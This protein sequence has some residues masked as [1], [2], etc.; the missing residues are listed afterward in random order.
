MGRELV[1]GKLKKEKDNLYIIDDEGNDNFVCG[2]NDFTNEIANMFYNKQTYTLIAVPDDF[3]NK[4]KLENYQFKYKGMSEL[5]EE[6][7]KLISLNS[8]KNC[9]DEHIK[10]DDNEYFKLEDALNSA[11]IARNNSSNLKIFLEFSD[12]IE[13]L[14]KEY[15]NWYSISSD[16]YEILSKYTYFILNT[17]EENSDGSDITKFPVIILSE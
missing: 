14:E 9:C 2:R 13:T 10:I 15:D 4:I 11:K 1:I 17:F 3:L 5:I 8:I 7:P 16:F 12:F 6:Q